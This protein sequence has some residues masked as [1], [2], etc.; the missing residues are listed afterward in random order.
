MSTQSNLQLVRDFF[1]A[2]DSGKV[3]QVSNFLA[4]DAEFNIMGMGMPMKGL[5]EIQEGF[6][7]WSRSFPDLKSQIV[8]IFGSE[9]S[10]VVEYI[11]RGTHQGPIESPDGQVIEPTQRKIEVPGCDV[12]RI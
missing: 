4:P 10:V 8:N 1:Q 11:G 6:Q 2:M 12:Y 5:S 3:D 7:M 9:D